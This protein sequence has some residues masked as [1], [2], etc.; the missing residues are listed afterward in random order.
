MDRRW[1][2]TLAFLAMV[3]LVVLPAVASAAE[4]SAP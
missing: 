2:V 1:F 4:L 3:G